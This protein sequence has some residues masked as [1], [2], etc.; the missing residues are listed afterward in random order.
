MRETR[1][2]G[3]DHLETTGLCRIQSERCTISVNKAQPKMGG[4]DPDYGYGRGQSPSGR[5]TYRAG[6]KPVGQSEC[7][8]CGRLGHFD[9]TVLMGAAMETGSTALGSQRS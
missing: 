6:D 2:T 5:D 7:S 4:D 8:K 3:G 1:E 9:R